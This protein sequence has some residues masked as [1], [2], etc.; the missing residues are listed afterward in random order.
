[1]EDGKTG[2]VVNPTNYGQ[3]SAKM[4][5]LLTDAPLR[6]EMGQRA[7]QRILEKFT[8]DSS[9]KRLIEEVEG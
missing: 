1:M 4:K 5:L 8:L 3:I 9:A 6:S 2:Y 7:K